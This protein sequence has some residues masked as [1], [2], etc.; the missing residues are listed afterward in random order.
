MTLRLIRPLALLAIDQLG[1]AARHELAAEHERPDPAAD[2]KRRV[3]QRQ[4]HRRQFVEPLQRD[5]AHHE[6]AVHRA[7]MRLL[8][9]QAEE[10]GHG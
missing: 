9:I 6:I 5:F 10:I 2:E 1:L 7:R 3:L 8:P 4:H